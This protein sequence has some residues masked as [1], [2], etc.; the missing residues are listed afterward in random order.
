MDKPVKAAGAPQPAI[1]TMLDARLSAKLTLGVKSVAFADLCR[2]LSAMAGIDCTAADDV[3]DDKITLFCTDRPLHLVLREIAE[4]FEFEW[5]REGTAPAFRYVLTQSLEARKREAALRAQEDGSALALLDRELAKYRAY[6]GLTP[7]QLDAMREGATSEEKDRI[8]FFRYVLMPAAN[9]FAELSQ[10]HRDALARGAPLEFHSRANGPDGLPPPVAEALRTEFSASQARVF[11]DSRDVT[12][13]R[14]SAILSARDLD[15]SVRLTL[16]PSGAGGFA[17]NCE[18][19]VRVPSLR[20]EDTFSSGGLPLRPAAESELNNAALNA[21]SSGLPE[22]RKAVSLDFNPSGFVEPGLHMETYSLQEGP[23]VSS[24]DFLE[25][26][27]E[28]TGSDIIADSFAGAYVP[29][30]LAAERTPLFDALC[31][32]CDRLHRSLEPAGRAAPLPQRPVLS[33]ARQ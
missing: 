4:H 27:H 5:R 7:A 24:A 28:A 18:R 30:M 3:A 11:E 25:A 9:V 13:E 20:V 19:G 16:A 1:D 21:G 26:V 2:Q 12:T 33:T 17:F 10:G 6:L 8:R 15:W 32:D 22:M 14:R 31:R 23:R 29:R